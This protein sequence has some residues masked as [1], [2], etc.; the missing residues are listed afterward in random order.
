MHSR[1]S[2]AARRRIATTC[3]LGDSLIMVSSFLTASLSMYSP[4]FSQAR[5]I[6]A[7]RRLSSREEAMM[8]H[9]CI[10]FILRHSSV[11]V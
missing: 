7:A 2:C 3:S 6:N 4:L 9:D 8:I 11:P 1:I 5:S 10:R